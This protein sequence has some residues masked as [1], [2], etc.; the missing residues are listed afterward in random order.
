MLEITKRRNSPYWQI[1][2]TYQ[3]I[4]VRES[5]G[6]PD[7]NQAEKIL[8]K[9]IQEIDRRAT[10]R[11]SVADAINS[12]KEAGG[13]ETYLEE[14][15]EVLGHIA[16]DVITQ[17]DIDLGAREAYGGYKRGEKG[18]I[19]KHKSSTIK[20]QF[21]V[22]LA[23]VLHH[24]ARQR[25]MPY[26]EIK[27][28]KDTRPPPE[29]AEPGWYKALWKTCDKD[30]KRLTMFLLLTGCRIQECLD[31]DWNDVNLKEGWAFVGKTKTPGEYRT[32]RLPP[33]LVK[34]LKPKK[35]GKLFP[36]RDRTQVR[37]YL[38]KACKKAKIPYL[39]THKI[40]SHTYG[41]LMRRYAGMDTQ[42][43]VATGRWKSRHSAE[44]YVHASLSEESLKADILAKLFK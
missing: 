21:Y 23:A 22:P 25:W 18:R 10:G 5:T 40:G 42:G 13:E 27:L 34:I 28:P 6:T 14:I 32:I 38:K 11:R 43:L 26:L 41:T 2:G 12:Y 31:M 30:M 36:Y 44:R 4:R 39:S 35:T 7:K 33:E 37:Y 8:G 29:W 3:G 1:T 24:A 19:R 17:E 20:R 9:R 16:L 15:E